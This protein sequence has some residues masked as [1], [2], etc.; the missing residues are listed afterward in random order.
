[1]CIEKQSVLTLASKQFL[2]R[3]IVII[4]LIWE[5]LKQAVCSFDQC[6]D[7]KRQLAGTLGMS[8][9]DCVVDIIERQKI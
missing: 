4:P 5:H 6:M 3:Q 9:A 7:V 8:L 1:M 2:K